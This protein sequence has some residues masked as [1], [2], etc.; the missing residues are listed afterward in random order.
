MSLFRRSPPTRIFTVRAER[1]NCL[2]SG[3]RTE[4]VVT[5]PAYDFEDA[6]ER[7]RAEYDDPDFA[8]RWTDV[9]SVREHR[10][11]PSP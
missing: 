7:V 10:V 5:L 3:G 9:W 2:V 1:V 6:A 11:R 8:T 4:V